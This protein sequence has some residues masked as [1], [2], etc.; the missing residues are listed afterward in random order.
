[1]DKVDIF[2]W[3]RNTFKKIG[4]TSAWES[5][6]PEIWE[7]AVPFK[8]N[9]IKVTIEFVYEWHSIEIEF[10]SDEDEKNF[11]SLVREEE[12]RRENN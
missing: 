4:Y 7:F 12:K 8:E 5:D 3:C 1:M 10:S 2:E 9:I 6:D 11:Y